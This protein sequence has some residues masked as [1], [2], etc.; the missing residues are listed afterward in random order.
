MKKWFNILLFSGTA[1]LLITSCKKDEDKTVLIPQNAPKL[2]ASATTMVLDSN[3]RSTNVVTFNWNKVSYGYAAVVTYSLE[4]SLASDNFTSSALVEIGTDVTTAGFTHGGLDTILYQTVGLEANVASGVKVRVRADVKKGGSASG[5][6][7]VAPVYSDTV[8]M[9]IT[10][11]Q[12][13]LVY[14]VVYVPGAYQGWTPETAN[15]LASVKSD[16]A[17]EGYVNYTTGN[18]AFKIT[19]LPDWTSSYGSGG[20]DNLSKTGGDLTVS[21][22]G[23]YRLEANTSTLKWSATKTDWGITGSA[24]P[25]GT[26][27]DTKMTYN[28]AAQTWSVTTNLVAGGLKFR[29]NSDASNAKNTLGL[30]KGKLAAGGNDITVVT[31]GNYTITLDLSKAAGNYSYALKKN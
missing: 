12:F 29:A 15:T 20:G 26:T 14:P 11:Y 25:G 10:P 7:A 16:N 13:V 19:P 27:T 4:F 6:S 18:L 9:T 17:Y 21:S 2:T 23:Y 8:N 22:A 3:K 28:A 24:T 30:T 31:V 1:A 5:P